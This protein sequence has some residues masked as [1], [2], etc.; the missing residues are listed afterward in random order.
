M[1]SASGSPCGSAT[2]YRDARLEVPDHVVRQE[3]NGAA[4]EAGQSA[5]SASVVLRVREAVARKLRL[6]LAQRVG[7]LGR[8]CVGPAAQHSVRLRADEAVASQTLASFDRLE[9]ERV[10]AARNLE[11]SRYGRLQVRGYVPKHGHEIVV[12]R[13][14]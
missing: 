8:V 14:C 5:V 10:I 7:A 6:Y 9:E 11:E 12:A 4:R 2:W 3:A 13:S 1:N